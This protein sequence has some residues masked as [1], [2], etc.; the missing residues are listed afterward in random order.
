[1]AEL[2]KIHATGIKDGQKTARCDITISSPTELA[3][4]TEIDGY[5]LMNGS[6]A[7]DI[8]NADLYGLKNGTWYKQ[9]DNS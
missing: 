1:M 6:I 5:V 8:A 4:L 2:M 9:T 7:W 3:S